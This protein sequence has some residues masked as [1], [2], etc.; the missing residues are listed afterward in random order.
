MENITKVANE[1]AVRRERILSVRK[2]MDY[3]HNK[4]AKDLITLEKHEQDTHEMLSFGKKIQTKFQTEPSNFLLW[5]IM[6]GSSLPDDIE[7]EMELDTPDHDIE[8]FVDALI[9]D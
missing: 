2:K 1:E 8:R 4:L 6:I 3:Y 7:L 5:H 9:K